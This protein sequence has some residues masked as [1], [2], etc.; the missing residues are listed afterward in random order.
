MKAKFAGALLA[1]TVSMAAL[2]GMKP[3]YA[4]DRPLLGAQIWI[5]P[6]QTPLGA[7]FA[8]DAAESDDGSLRPASAARGGAA[9]RLAG[10]VVAEIR[11][12]G[13]PT[14]VRK[15]H[16][17]R[18]ASIFLDLFPALVANEHCSTSHLFPPRDGIA[19][20]ED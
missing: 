5:E 12:L 18:R 20:T 1:G 17:Q 8:R 16:A 10:A 4:A 19:R 9:G 6:G 15:G 3:A 7:A 11:D 2:L 13:T 14:G